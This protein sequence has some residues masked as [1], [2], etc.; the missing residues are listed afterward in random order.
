MVYYI[1][2]GLL[3][4][5]GAVLLGIKPTPKKKVLFCI[6]AGISW[7]LISGLRGLSVG[8]DTEN[9]RNIFFKVS[10]QSWATLWEECLKG[11]GGDAEFRDFGYSFLIKGFATVIPNFQVFLIFVAL[12]FHIPL[13]VWICKESRYPLMSFLI[14]ST[15]FYSFFA[16]TGLRQTIA[17]SLAVFCAFP[18]IKKRKLIPFLLLVL[19]ASTIH[20][21]ALIVLPMYFF[22]GRKI[23]RPVM[24]FSLAGVGIVAVFRNEL[25]KWLSDV[26]DY[27]YGQYDTEGPL[28]F[29]A[30]IAVIWV[31]VFVFIPNIHARGRKKNDYRIFCLCS[32]AILLPLVFVN[33]NLMRT[34]QYFSLIL[35]V[36]IPELIRIFEKKTRIAIYAV[37]T[38]VLLA[39]LFKNQ[40][41]YVFFW[42]SI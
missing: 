32:A 11:L 2:I 28:V 16:I 33:P 22:Y 10:E 27:Q 29:T 41:Q 39:A 38:A 40:P 20:K 23:N 24:A 26:T 34:V 36:L 42:Q 31:A 37:C 7:I 12:L 18:F 9:Y 3:I 21:S 17:T 30:I 8:V 19:L 1:N 35:I 15:L 25:L 5:L 4:V 6:L 14:Y 13:T